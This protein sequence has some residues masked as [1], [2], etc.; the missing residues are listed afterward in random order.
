METVTLNIINTPI[1]VSLSITNKQ[2]AVLMGIIDGASYV[3]N[4]NSSYKA[5]LSAGQTLTLPDIKFTD[6]D[7][8]IYY[9]PACTDI[10]AKPCVGGGNMDMFTINTGA[11]VANVQKAINH[12]YGI[13][14]GATDIDYRLFDL[15][16]QERFFNELYPD[17]SDPLNKLLLTVGDDNPAGL[18]LKIYI[19]K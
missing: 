1:V 13:T 5:T 10:T 12:D 6:S 16:G 18:L 19:K 17:P 15:N 14:Y 11:L 7:G 4:S 9:Y 2:S 8:A 3:T